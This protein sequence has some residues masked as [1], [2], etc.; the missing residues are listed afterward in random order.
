MLERVRFSQFKRILV[1]DGV[2]DL[3]SWSH[4]ELLSFSGHVQGWASFLSRTWKI[5][6]TLAKE[7]LDVIDRQHTAMSIA[8]K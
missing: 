8:N 2:D 4:K 6:L 1:C 7:R 5:G 3:T